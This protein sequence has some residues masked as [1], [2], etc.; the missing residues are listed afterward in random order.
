VIDL[1]THV[2]PRID[3]G[4]ASMEE[5]VALARA[6]ADDGI[7]QMAATPH[8][9]SDHPGV[10][11]A[12]LRGQCDELNSRLRR[13][14]VPV[15]VVPGGEVDIYWAQTASED[16]LK[17]A[18]Y[19]QRGRYLLVETPYGALPD[20]FENLL[21][22]LT[23]REFGILLAHPERSPSFQ[24]HPERLEA[25]VRSGILLQITAAALVDSPRRS[26][27]RR[28]AEA[29]VA[30]R[31]AHVVATDAHGIR[32]RRSASLSLA[33]AA[34]DRLAAGQGRRMTKEIPAA[35]LAGDDVPPVTPRTRPR[36]A[37]RLRQAISSRSSAPP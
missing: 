1:H 17:A 8:L 31:R 37:D 22:Q 15:E 33:A 26:A 10:D 25:L 12:K 35:I 9:R 36:L 20:G 18:S 7:V 11:P 24:R 3:D 23:A 13:R 29:M 30:E 2:L 14:N 5:A 34:A 21:F 16:L 4:P 6:E 27:S 28:L 32:L 19:G